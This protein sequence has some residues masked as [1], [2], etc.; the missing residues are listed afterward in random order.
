M[1]YEE[2]AEPIGQ[3]VKKTK[4]KKVVKENEVEKLERELEELKKVEIPGEIEEDSSELT[5]L[6]MVVKELPLQPVRK[7][8]D[9]E[10]GIIT[11]F[12]TIEESLTNMEKYFSDL[13]GG[14]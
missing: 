13:S 2:E 1:G 3:K 8:K 5:N 4:V 9:E 11:N 7:H 12:I 6:T 14:A 10:T